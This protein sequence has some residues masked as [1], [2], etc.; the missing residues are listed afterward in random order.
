M[1][2]EHRYYYGYALGKMNGNIFIGDMA[3]GVCMF[4]P[5]A[6]SLLAEKDNHVC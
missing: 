3:V 1:K 6:A 4:D 2:A 5:L